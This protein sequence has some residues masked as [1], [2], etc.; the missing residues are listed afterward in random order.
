MARV[1]NAI[2][3][4][5]LIFLIIS[6]S[7]SQ[8]EKRQNNS[9]SNISS[10]LSTDIDQLGKLLNFDNY[11]PSSVKFK[12]KVIGNSGKNERIS[13]PGPSDYSLEALLYF[14]SLTFQKII[15]FDRNADFPPPGYN[16][17]AFKF[18]WLD[19]AIISELGESDIHYTGHP[20]LHFGT[21]NGRSW[22]LDKKI[23]I[24]YHTN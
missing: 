8:V 21:T 22:Y 23:L 12:Y 1:T 18:N 13:P 17:E 11:K 5:A 19:E 7:C 24:Q 4:I 10:G 6:A 16:Q 20:D 15:E 14:D 9:N 2:W 3:C